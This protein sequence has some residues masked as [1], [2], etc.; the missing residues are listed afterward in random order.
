[1]K[2]EAA[3]IWDIPTRL[4]HWGVAAC[5]MTNLWISEEGSDPHNWIGYAAAGL[6]GVRAIWGFMGGLPS[7]FS[8]FPMRGGDLKQFVHNSLRGIYVDYPGH[9][10]LASVSY[11][12]VWAL[13]LAMAITGWMMG[14]DQFWGEEWLEETHEML[15][16]GF[17]IFLVV[18]GIGIFIDARQHKRKTWLGMLT[19]RR[20]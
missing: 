18:H 1:M 13:V 11:I 3:Q 2:R 4:I 14:L 7:R 19:G 12:F 16:N 5:I 9:N 17:I 8:S 6:V 10:P 20:E 15:A